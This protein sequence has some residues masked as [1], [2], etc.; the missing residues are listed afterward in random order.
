MFSFKGMK[1]SESSSLSELDKKFLGES[2]LLSALSLELCLSKSSNATADKSET[3]ASPCSSMDTFSPSQ[4][5]FHN[6]N[7]QET[8]NC[9]LTVPSKVKFSTPMFLQ[10]TKPAA[11]CDQSY[12]DFTASQISWDV[13][14]IKPE[15]HSPNFLMDSRAQ[16]QIPSP[17]PRQPSVEEVS[18]W[19]GLVKGQ[20]CWT[21]R[22]NS[23]NKTIRSQLCVSPATST[24]KVLNW[25]MLKCE[26][27]FF[28]TLTNTNKGRNFIFDHHF[29]LLQFM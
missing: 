23:T 20:M 6:S 7:V 13:S 11:S 16:E 25:K 9:H 8:D 4:F 5:L 1:T 12:S 14:V 22:P 3:G 24:C 19:S 29:T 2:S 26:M 27:V 21:F 15:N 17:K 28:L 18:P 10:K